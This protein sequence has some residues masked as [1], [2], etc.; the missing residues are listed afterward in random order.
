M[1]KPGTW[2]YCRPASDTVFSGAFTSHSRAA[3]I[4]TRTTPIWL[5]AATYPVALVHG[6]YPRAIRLTLRGWFRPCC[7]AANCRILYA[8]WRFL[9]FDP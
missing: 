1:S 7:M 2:P 6:D 8:Y 3:G 4:R 9:S 5:C